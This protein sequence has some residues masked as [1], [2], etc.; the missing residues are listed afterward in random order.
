MQEVVNRMTVY[1]QDTIQGR[2]E[3][4]LKRVGRQLMGDHLRLVGGVCVESFT[5]ENALGCC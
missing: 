4:C 1:A 3:V 5:K 2:T